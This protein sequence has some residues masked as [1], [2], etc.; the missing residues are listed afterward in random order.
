[1]SAE[2]SF[3]RGASLGTHKSELLPLFPYKNKRWVI[4]HEI[5]KW[6]SERPLRIGHRHQ[7]LYNLRDLQPSNIWGMGSVTEGLDLC[8]LI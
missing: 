1:M 4:I 2:G 3:P 7:E 6:D 5:I 8:S